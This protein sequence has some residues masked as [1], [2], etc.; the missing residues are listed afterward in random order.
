MKTGVIGGALQ[1]NP[2]FCGGLFEHSFV[3]IGGAADQVQS[4]RVAQFF[5]GELGMLQ[6]GLRTVQVETG[7]G[8]SE[9]SFSI[10]R[11]EPESSFKIRGR[12]CAFAL[13]V[14]HEATIHVGSCDF[15]I[16]LEGTGKRCFGLIEIAIVFVDVAGQQGK[17][18][19]LGQ[20]RLIFGRQ[21]Q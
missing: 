11:F 17:C 14:Q 1:G 12:G 13:I 9:M 8:E 2:I 16:M 10:L 20:D 4:H 6:G 15:R 3:A 5:F 18:G 19:I 21:R 7:I